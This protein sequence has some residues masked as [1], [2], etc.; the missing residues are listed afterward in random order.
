M[1]GLVG[2]P[3]GGWTRLELH[4]S[5]VFGCLENL[6]VLRAGFMRGLAYSREM[7]SCGEHWR[8]VRGP[9]DC[10]SEMPGNVLK[11]QA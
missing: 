2:A 7:G 1:S 10:I 4:S 8:G 5:R 11:I 9:R 6:G 3:K